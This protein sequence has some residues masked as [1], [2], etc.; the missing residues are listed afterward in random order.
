MVTYK[1]PE[2]GQLV[3]SQ[4]TVSWMFDM[5]GRGAEMFPLA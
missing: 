2:T 3:K 5:Q 1:N 4:F